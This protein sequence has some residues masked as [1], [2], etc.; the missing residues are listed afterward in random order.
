MRSPWARV[1]PSLL[2]GV[3]LLADNAEA[4]SWRTVTKTRQASGE[5]RLDVHVEYGAGRFQVRPG[6]PGSLY[7]MELTYDEEEFEPLASFDG[8]SLELGVD[9]HSGS[10]NLGKGENRSRMDLWLSTAVPMDLSLEFGA[11]A[12]DLDLG[13]IPLTSLSMKTGASETTLVISE[14]NREMMRSAELEVGAAEFTIRQL[15][16]LNAERLRIEAAVGDVSLDFTGQWVRGAEVDVELGL[17]ALEL[18]FPRSLGV[19]IIRDTFLTSM[20]ADGFTRNGDE[21][22]SENWDDA[23]VRVTVDVEAA[24]GT[25]DVGWVR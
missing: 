17:G 6:E 22:L 18:I 20:D 2:V 23:E 11:V 15:G 8:F 21:Y 1:I 16:N 7:R 12:A 5:E 13:G 14:P 9:G 4:Q 19:R 25:I 24:F 3:V 10:I